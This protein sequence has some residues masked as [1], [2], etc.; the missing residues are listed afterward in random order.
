[1]QSKSNRKSYPSDMSKAG[2]KKL[3]PLL[4]KPKSGTV[5]G[6]RPPEEVMEVINAIFYVLKTGC[7]WRCLPHDFPKW[8]TVYGYFWRWSKDGT[9]ELIHTWFVKKTRRDV[10]RNN[11]PSA[12]VIDSQSIKVTA[13]GGEEQGF[14]G[15]KGI[16]GRKRFILTDT[17]GLLLTVVVCSA[18][19]SEKEGAK[20]LLEYIKSKSYLEKLCS[21]IKLVW[22]DR[23]Y[24]GADLANW[25]KNLWGW[26]WE[27]VRRNQEAKGFVLLPRRW[28]V[29]RTFGWFNHARRLS[30]DYEYNPIH[31]QSM[32]YMASIK[33]MLNR[34]K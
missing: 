15:G 16:K 25:V 24:Q 33:I 27:V 1:M 34:I 28:V 32:V 18:A 30:K 29:E 5:K 21:R 9:W 23:G 17:L 2:W 11:R 3:K 4:P 7:S 8:S 14:D 13:F 6:G 12:A 22:A 20:K 19:V 26:T 10:F 31:S